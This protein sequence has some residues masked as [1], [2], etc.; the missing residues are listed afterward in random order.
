MDTSN[1]ILAWHFLP[2]DRRLTHDDGRLAI[3]G[4]TLSVG[5]PVRVRRHGLHATVDVVEAVLR[6]YLPVL[7]RVVLSGETDEDCGLWCAQHRKVLWMAD[8][9]SALTD[10]V[11]DECERLATTF[12]GEDGTGTRAVVREAIAAWR[13]QA[14]GALSRFE[15][16]QITD[17]LEGEKIRYHGL[18][19]RVGDED[20]AAPIVRVRYQRTLAVLTLVDDLLVRDGEAPGGASR[21]VSRIGL[22]EFRDRYG[23]LRPGEVCD[24]GYEKVGGVRDRLRAVLGGLAPPATASVDDGGIRER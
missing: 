5:T 10:F 1:E 13:R 16:G 2:Y 15:L 24:L 18:L 23:W 4:E 3:A 12:I 9:T 17:R 6:A 8:A 7:C 11:V 20:D 21:V 14:E 19:N 22:F